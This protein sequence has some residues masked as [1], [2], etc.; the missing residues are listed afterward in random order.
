[1]DK[2]DQNGVP[3]LNKEFKLGDS[4]LPINVP[5]TCLDAAEDMSKVAV[6]FCNGVSICFVLSIF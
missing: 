3:Y 1:M 5:V 6:G 4:R 2:L